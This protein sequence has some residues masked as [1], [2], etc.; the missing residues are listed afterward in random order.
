MRDW[1]EIRPRFEPWVSWKGRKRFSLLDIQ[2]E[3][4]FLGI[5]WLGIEVVIFR[6]PFDY[7]LFFCILGFGFRVVSG[8]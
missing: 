7:D 4:S 6:K 5:C 8:E 3:V 1:D 2:C